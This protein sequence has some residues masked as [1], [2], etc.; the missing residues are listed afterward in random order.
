MRKIFYPRFEKFSSWLEAR[1]TLTEDTEDELQ[2]KIVSVSVTVT[3]IIASIIWGAISFAIGL[4]W[5][6]L[7]MLLAALILGLNTLYFLGA[8]RFRV[9]LTIDLAVALV[10]PFIAQFLL[11]GFSLGGFVSLWAFP[12]VI[13]AG[14]F[15]NR[16]T[17][18]LWLLAYIALTIASAALESIAQQHAPPISGAVRTIIFTWNGIVI[19]SLLFLTVQSILRETE[20]ARDRADKLL[21]NILPKEIAKILK[22]DQRVI[23]DHYDEVSILFADVVNFTPLSSKMTPTELVGLLNEL[24]S[25]FDILVDHYGLEKIKTIGDCYMVAAGVPRQRPD[26]AIVLTSLALDMRD[27]VN[28]HEFL[29]HQLSIR[30]GLN[31]GSAVAGVIGQ[32]KFIYDLWGDAVNIAS[33]MESHG[34]GGVVQITEAVYERIKDS[35]DCQP[36]GVINVKGKGDMKVWYVLERQSTDDKL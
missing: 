2:R 36:H 4:Y 8:R 16:R 29:G 27:Y 22:G 35:F 17:A 33:R 30:I 24:F 9:Y 5:L 21:L 12:C 7:L 10:I 13:S 25:R 31:S 28:Q 20:A 1:I 23:A 34:S 11:G 3:G 32:R 14:I 15:L 26:H 6:G 18:Y 19:G